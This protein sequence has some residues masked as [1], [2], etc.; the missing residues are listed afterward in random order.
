[1][2]TV[3]EGQ[4]VSGID[5][6]VTAAGRVTGHIVDG[7]GNPVST[8]VRLFDMDGHDVSQRWGAGDGIHPSNGNTHFQENGSDGTYTLNGVAPGTYKVL[9]DTSE[10]VIYLD[11]TSWMPTW[12]GNGYSF[13]SATP[14]SVASGQTTTGIDVR[15][16]TGG[17]IS[18][19]LRNQVG[20]PAILPNSVPRSAV[21]YDSQQNVVNRG[22]I[23]NDGRFRIGGLLPGNYRLLLDSTAFAALQPQWFSG[24]QT[25]STADDIVVA[26]TNNV[27]LGD[28]RMTDAYPQA[29]VVSLTAPVEMA[30]VWGT[31]TTTA[32]VSDH[33][34]ISKVD[35]FLDGQ[36]AGSIRENRQNAF[37]GTYSISWD[38]TRVQPG[39]HFVTA[40]AFNVKGLY[41]DSQVAVEV[42]RPRYVRRHLK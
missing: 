2:I 42:V 5:G 10:D 8:A 15:L 35:F 38:A 27:V 31:I 3:A 33:E 28:I 7:N 32:Q 19:R 29:P 37:A 21:L 20:G 16:A 26:G 4:T 39:L 13:A 17:S 25:F 6:H 1:V 41:N 36:P 11:N 14:I 12:F 24:K 40:R 18:G 23:W 22:W 30:D 9:V 34:G